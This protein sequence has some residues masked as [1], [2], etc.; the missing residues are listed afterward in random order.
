MP[1]Q[2]PRTSFT[3]SVAERGSFSNRFLGI[4]VVITLSPFR[5]ATVPQSDDAES[6]QL[7]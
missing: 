4:N 6:R 5:P 1:V 2:K 7:I 3:H